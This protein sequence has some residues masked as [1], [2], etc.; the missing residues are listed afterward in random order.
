MCTRYYMDMSTELKPFVDR[1]MRSPLR[2]S[3]VVKLGKPMKTEGE[4]KPTDIVPVVAPN[5]K[6]MQPTVFPIVWGFTNPKVGSPLLN[7]R[8]ETAASK[9]FWKDAWASRRCVIPAS[10]YFEWEHLFLSDGTKKTGQKY[11]I[12]PRGSPVTYLADL[13]RIEEQRGIRLPVFTVLTREPGEAI[14]F[15]HDRMPVIL[16]K[17]M[18]RAWITQEG[19]PEAIVKEAVTDMYYEKAE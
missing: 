19:K 17:D 4:V 3:M 8:V 15:I 11:M 10:Y 1:A 7:A 9:P 6:T 12:Q 16:P 18:V 2:E 13:Y 5:A 14:R